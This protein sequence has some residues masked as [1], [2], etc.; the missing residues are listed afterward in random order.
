MPLV[1]K[2]LAATVLALLTVLG[3]SLT[4]RPQAGPAATGPRPAPAPARA[5]LAEAVFAMVLENARTAGMTL[6]EPMGLCQA[7]VA[8]HLGL[9]G[10]SVRERC[11]RAC[12]L[13]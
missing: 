11:D 7:C 12:G 6:P 1:K 8:A 5:D 10:E 4:S 13:R 9:P 2:I 3:L